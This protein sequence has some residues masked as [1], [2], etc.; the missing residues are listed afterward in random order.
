MDARFL[1]YRQV[2]SPAYTKF[3]KCLSASHHPLWLRGELKYQYGLVPRPSTP[4]QLELNDRIWVLDEEHS[5]SQNFVPLPR[6][7]SRI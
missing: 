1:L 3:L 6:N 7:L 2:A 4:F 5:H